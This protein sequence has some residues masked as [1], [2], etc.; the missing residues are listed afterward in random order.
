LPPA[1]RQG[2]GSPLRALGIAALLVLGFS[3][4]TFLQIG[5]AEIP[6]KPWLTML[7]FALNAGLT[8]QL[9]RRRRSFA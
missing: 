9:L 1:R 4:P 7:P 6:G 2:E 3:F 8:W 5:S